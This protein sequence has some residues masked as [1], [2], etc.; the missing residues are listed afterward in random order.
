MQCLATQEHNTV[1]ILSKVS[2]YYSIPNYFFIFV[3]SKAIRLGRQFSKVIRESYQHNMCGD[4]SCEDVPRGNLSSMAPGQPSRHNWS[5]FVVPIYLIM[6]GNTQRPVT[7]T[8][9]IIPEL[10]NTHV[11]VGSRCI[12]SSRPNDAY[13]YASSSLA[14]AVICQLFQAWPLEKAMITYHHVDPNEHTPITL[15]RLFRP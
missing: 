1:Y 8:G 13:I 5:G 12:N 3:I 10:N 7:H 9:K 11:L 6:S 2:L 15:F 4:F 14:Q